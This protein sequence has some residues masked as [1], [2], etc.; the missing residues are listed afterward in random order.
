MGAFGSVAWMVAAKFWIFCAPAVDDDDDDVDDEG[1]K[2][3]IFK[4]DDDGELLVELFWFDMPIRLAIV[5]DDDEVEEEE[6]VAEDEGDF[7]SDK[8]VDMVFIWDFMGVEVDALL[9]FLRDLGVLLGVNEFVDEGD[10]FE[11]L[12]D[13][14]FDWKL[15]AAVLV[16]EEEEGDEEDEATVEVHAVDDDD[17]TGDDVDWDVAWKVRGGGIIISIWCCFW[18][19]FIMSCSFSCIWC[20]KL[21]LL[22]LLE[23]TFMNWDE[24]FWSLFGF[25]WFN[26]KFVYQKSSAMSFVLEL[27]LLWITCVITMGVVVEL[28]LRAF[29][30]CLLIDSLLANW[31]D[32]VLLFTKIIGVKLLAWTCVLFKLLLWLTLFCI[33]FILL[34][35]WKSNTLRFM[36][37]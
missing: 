31:L 36:I 29:S 25:D 11:V 24:D 17:A 3:E 28:F 23:W 2:R 19:W 4:V 5:L 37:L 34:L 21:L 32:D 35:V 13:G 26:C 18:F 8:C 20:W 7:R 10:D 15:E 14:V 6:A 27:V 30:F 33:R 12:A 22:L 9:L 16:E 1:D